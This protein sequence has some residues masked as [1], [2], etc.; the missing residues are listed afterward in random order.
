MCCETLC[1]KGMTHS[2]ADKRHAALQRTRGVG[3]AAAGKLAVPKPVN[4]PSLRKVRQAPC[5]HHTAHIPVQAVICSLRLQENAGNDPTTQIVPSKS[6][7]GWQKPEPEQA[8]ETE[9]AASLVASSNWASPQVQ[10]QLAGPPEPGPV[11][12]NPPRARGLNPAEYPSLSAAAYAAQQQ[13]Q[14]AAKQPGFVSGS[15]QVRYMGAGARRIC[16]SNMLL[17]A[18]RSIHPALMRAASIAVD[19]HC[20]C[21]CCRPAATGTRTSGGGLPRHWQSLGRRQTGA[22]PCCRHPCDGWGL[23]CTCCRQRS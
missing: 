23:I 16:A 15:A 4:L 21:H 22:Q 18:E 6:G 8:T 20:V 13:Q 9:R 5:C 7:V 11:P 1:C 2:F 10:Q 3:S 19:E 17:Q 14:Q 12:A